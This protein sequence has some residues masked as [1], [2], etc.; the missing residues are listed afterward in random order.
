MYP[1]AHAL[2]ILGRESDAS[3][4][5]E[6]PP[7]VRDAGKAAS[8]VYD[9]YAIDEGDGFLVRFI[10]TPAKDRL[11]LDYQ[12]IFNEIVMGTEPVEEMFEAFRLLCDELGIRAAIDEVNARLTESSH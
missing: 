6:L 12:S 4:P 11:E 3:V 5:G 1:S 8:D 10:R 7:D 9:S 2:F